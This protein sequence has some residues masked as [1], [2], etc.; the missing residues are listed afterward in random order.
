LA[1]VTLFGVS[2]GREHVTNVLLHACST[3]LLF[4]W[5]RQTT[6]SLW[7]SA[8][9]AAL[10]ALHPLHVESVAWIS[11]RKD[12][13]SM[14]FW[15]LSLWAYTGYVR[16]PRPGRYLLVLLW[17]ACGLMAKPMVVTLPFVLLLLDVWPLG[18][19]IPGAAGAR[20]VWFRLAREKVPFLLLSAAS[21]VVTFLVQQR[22]GAM[23]AAQIFPLGLRLENAVV[24]PVIYL[25]QML[26]PMRLIVFYVHPDVIPIW[27]VVAAVGLLAGVSLVALRSTQRPYF[28]VGWFWY[29]GT[30]LPVSGV[31]QVGMQARAD[32][33]TY[34]P[35]VGILIVLSWGVA[36]LLSRWQIRRVIGAPAAIVL[37]IA[38]GV[39]SYR[40][41]G[42]GPRHGLSWR[43]S[44]PN[45]AARTTPSRI[46][47]R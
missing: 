31:V 21:S 19:V 38:C 28:A 40:Q 44:W 26:W 32:R 41:V 10:F 42:Y 47:T 24:S 43:R 29:L 5:L 9:T 23:N 27:Q 2:A 12:V 4:G 13:L 7:R 45:Q 11:E 18:R 33:Y 1:E 3:L 14:L 39:L 36:D 16:H 20:A 35:L 22:G 15:M 8:A 34:L 6:G 46:S 17:F 25:W 30:L 37:T